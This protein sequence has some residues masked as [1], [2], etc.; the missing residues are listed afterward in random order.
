M[1]IKMRHADHYNVLGIGKDSTNHE[2]KTAYRKLALQYHPDKNPDPLAKE[3]FKKVA[4]S[5]STLIDSDKRS[6]Y[7]RRNN[8]QY[9]KKF[10][11]NVPPR[12]PSNKPKNGAF[13]T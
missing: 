1:K 6:A 8:P 2:I 3:V 7:D 10:S 5:Y 11:Y 12:H 9:Q 13:Y 4:D